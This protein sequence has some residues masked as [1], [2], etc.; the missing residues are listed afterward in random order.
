MGPGRIAMPRYID[1]GK[2][3][4]HAAF[5]VYKFKW[6]G[7]GAPGLAAVPRPGNDH[8]FFVAADFRQIDALH[9]L[10]KYRYRCRCSTVRC[11][12]PLSRI[13]LSHLLRQSPEVCEFAGRIDFSH[14]VK[15]LHP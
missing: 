12:K 5:L 13:L 6:V 11:M 4:T 15:V 2:F 1:D 3:V 14:A 9:S 7:F 8:S 10:L